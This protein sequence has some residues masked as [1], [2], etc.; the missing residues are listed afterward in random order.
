MLE[1]Q[2]IMDALYG[3]VP[4]YDEERIQQINDAAA[5][6]FHEVYDAD[7]H[8]VDE[9]IA[10]NPEKLTEVIENAKQHWEEYEEQ[11]KENYYD[12]VVLLLLQYYDGKLY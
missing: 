5:G 7:P 3:K 10:E 9:Q 8:P 1:R 12:G 2:H 6:V 4:I 11:H